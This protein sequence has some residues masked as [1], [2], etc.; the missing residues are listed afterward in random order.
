MGVRGGLEWSR[1]LSTRPRPRP[2]RPSTTPTTTT[3]YHSNSKPYDPY[4]HPSASYPASYPASHPASHCA[5]AVR[6]LCVCCAHISSIQPKAPSASR[7]AFICTESS[8]HSGASLRRLDTCMIAGEGPT[9]L[10]SGSRSG[11]G[12][13]VRARVRAR[14]RVSMVV[15]VRGPPAACRPCRGRGATSARRRRT[16]GPWATCTGRRRPR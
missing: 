3:P 6:A 5:R 1:I 16:W 13:V 4:P 11:L 15:R 7:S 2:L 12:S 8:Y 10:G 9:W 14:V